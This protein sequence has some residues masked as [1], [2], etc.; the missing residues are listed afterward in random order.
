MAEYV[1][2]V[3]EDLLKG[4][5]KAPDQGS[6]TPTLVV[7]LGGTGIKVLRTLKKCLYHYSEQRIKL[8]GID[9]D[10]GENRK[11]PELPSLNDG[12][13]CILNQDVAIRALA[14]SDAGFPDYKHIDEF[15]PDT[16]ENYTGIRQTVREKVQTRKG[17]GQFRR[18]GRLLF[19]ANVNNGANL[20]TL[21][22]DARNELIGLSTRLEKEIAGIQVD[23]GMKIFV[24]SSAAGGTGAGIFLETVALLRSHFNGS[25]D[26]I[27]AFLLLP[28]AALDKELTNPNQEIPNTRGNAM[29][30]IRE[31]QPILLGE[32][33]HTFIFDKDLQ[34]KYDG[35]SPLLNDCYL[36]DNNLMDR[37]P[38]ETWMDMC[39]AMGYFLY[40]LVGTGVGAAKDSG[41]INGQVEK[42][43][44]REAI[45]CVFNTLGIG[46]LEYP[47]DEL[48]RLGIQHVLG[49]LLDD[50]L[51]PKYDIK[52]AAAKAT[53]ALDILGLRDIEDLKAK[54]EFSADSLDEAKFLDGEQLKKLAL[55][56]LDDQF[57]GVADVKMNSI[58]GEL[59]AHNEH[60]KQKTQEISNQACRAASEYARTLI[61]G[62]HALAKAQFESL[63]LSVEK[64]REKLQ[65]DRE[66]R[67]VEFTELDGELQQLKKTI[68]FWDCYLDLKPRKRFILRVNEYLR[69]RVENKLDP[70]LSEILAEILKHLNELSTQ[71]A[72]TGLSME[73][74]RDKNRNRVD[75]ASL[76]GTRL[77]FIQSALSP[78]QFGDWLKGLK[79]PLRRDFTASN[80][81]EETILREALQDAGPQLKRKLEDLNLI[82]DAKKN[83]GLL[84]R[85]QSL[86]AVSQPFMDFV[87]TAPPESDLIPQK[88][89]AGNFKEKDDSFLQHFPAAGKKKIVG[90][91]TRNQHLI[92][93]TRTLHGFGIAH[94][95]EYQR[96]LKCYKEKEWYFHTFSASEKLPQFEMI[97]SE[98][99]TQLQV[100]G[101]SLM[102]DFI[103][104]RGSNYYRNIVQ[105][106]DDRNYYYLTFKKEPGT[107]AQKLLDHCLVLPAKESELRPRS[108][109]LI[110]NSLES[111]L[112]TLG[113]LE[114][115]TLCKEIQDVVEDFISSVGKVQ[116]Q[117][118]IKAFMAEELIGEI[119]K[120][121]SNTE[122]RDLL[123]E[124]ADALGK[125]ANNIG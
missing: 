123:N 101:L 82:E 58:D 88:F 60:L 56:K 80:L 87:K 4:I 49:E 124:I 109:N 10:D 77:G 104:K 7:G 78:K 30:V 32:I 99:N 103:T 17:A 65:A 26:I 116:S 48:G 6:Y 70:Y 53:E 72:N 47:V 23:S 12:E 89:V 73:I 1:D 66:R 44:G 33:A 36:I 61:T 69:S 13:L 97:S 11:F 39:Q 46:V 16:F 3:L 68:N 83:I 117:S 105:S 15:L 81:K 51:N 55:K 94:W 91:Q 75:S 125:Y 41:A 119:K 9:S 40:S 45:P 35:K 79:L 21:F 8:L 113:R 100:F 25:T 34:F 90:I 54:M 122:R 64:L 28:G 92:I 18:A 59:N 29:G 85:V 112:E 98:R 63:R 38:V 95:S 106:S 52:L 121:Q 20:N 62:N 43:K 84:K 120:T 27:T 67:K 110:A 14:R 96:A 37:T 93:C 71:L 5:Y 74:L 107:F 42:D 22:R 57:I 86:N 111:A 102:F 24:V 2:T 115:A 108:E 118:L 114:W 19:D 31:L 50:W 76:S